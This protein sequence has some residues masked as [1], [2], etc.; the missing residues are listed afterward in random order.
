MSKS[1]FLIDTPKC[2]GMCPMSGTD[3]CRKWNMKDLR[4]FPK[5][6][7]LREVPEPKKIDHIKMEFDLIGVTE[8]KKR[9]IIEDIKSKIPFNLE[10][11]GSIQSVVNNFNKEFPVLKRIEK[12]WLIVGTIKPEK[13]K[14]KMRQQE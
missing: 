11:R 6:C 3:V 2:C 9:F 4:T 14:R 10:V 12:G 1:I 5:E 7:P 13:T 8:D